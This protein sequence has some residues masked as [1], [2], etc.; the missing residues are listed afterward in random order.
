[1]FCRERSEMDG[2]PRDTPSVVMAGE[3]E[4]VTEAASEPCAGRKPNFWGCLI[5][6]L[7]GTRDGLFGRSGRGRQGFPGLC[8]WL[9]LLQLGLREEREDIREYLAKRE[10]PA[11]VLEK[12]RKINK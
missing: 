4:E 12:K 3:F 1:M 9:C 7:I 6:S 2:T 11:Y 5:V 8:L 10:R